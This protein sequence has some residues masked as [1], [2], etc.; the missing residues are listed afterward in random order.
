MGEGVADGVNVGVT[1]DSRLAARTGVGVAA[2]VGVGII[3]GG[4][5]TSI[6][7]LAQAMRIKAQRRKLSRKILVTII[8]ISPLG[9][10]GPPG[11]TRQPGIPLLAF[12][13]AA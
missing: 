3:G 7:T 8:T 2:G 13:A 1:S 6:R 11:S 10:A 5:V 4:V 9:D 12:M